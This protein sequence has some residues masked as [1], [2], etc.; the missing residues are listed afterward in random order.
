MLF[1]GLELQ[2]EMPRRTLLDGKYYGPFGRRSMLLYVRAKSYL[3][4]LNLN[5][6]ELGKGTSTEHFH[7]LIC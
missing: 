4:F 1:P 5:I 7:F 6:V 2:I 3:G